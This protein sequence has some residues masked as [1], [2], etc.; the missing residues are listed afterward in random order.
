VAAALLFTAAS[1]LLPDGRWAAHGLAAAFLA[2]AALAA[3]I[4]WAAWLKRL[5]LVEPLAAGIALM[6]LFLPDGGVR[7]ASLLA[8]STLALGAMTLLAATTPFPAILDA[9]RR[10]R[11]PSLLVTVLALTHRYLFL[12][13]NELQ[14]MARARRSRSR[15][16]DGVRQWPHIAG[17]AGRLFIRGTE[18]AERVAGAM[19]ARGWKP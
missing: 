13:R 1:A 17:M 7:F 9:L 2:A 18:R 11:V 12:L 14:R 8:K 5:L 10:F 19:A 3:R 4:R 15:G 6:A 16:P